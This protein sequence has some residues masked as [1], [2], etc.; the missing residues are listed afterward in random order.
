MFYREKNYRQGDLQIL[1]GVDMQ[2]IFEGM[3]MFKLKL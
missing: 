2:K 1:A 3:S